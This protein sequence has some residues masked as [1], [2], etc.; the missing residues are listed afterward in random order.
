MLPVIPVES[1]CSLCG[2]RSE[3]RITQTIPGEGL[4]D[5]DTR[6]AEPARLALPFWVQRCPKCG[7]CATDITLDYPLA[8]RVIRSAEYQAVL[9]KRGV[10]EKAREFLAW[11]LI[12]AANSE[13]GGAGWSAL[14]AA[15]VCDDGE[16]PAPAAECRKLALDYFSRQRAGNGRITGFEDP[17]V[18]ELVLAD[19]CRRTG[20]YAPALKWVESGL[21]RQPSV[22]VY[23]ALLKEQ[24]LVEEKDRGA[25]TVME[26]LN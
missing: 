21:G 26:L 5:L 2:T 7:Y 22:M 11:S 17:G 6:P 18:E 20:Q 23:R 14:H 12:E 24:G 25:H 8:G 15:W 3:Q 19:L 1:E 13:F 10:P 4:P 9:R 16:K